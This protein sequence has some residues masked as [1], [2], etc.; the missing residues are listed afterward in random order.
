MPV[1]WALRVGESGP[2]FRGHDLSWPRGMREACA[3][4]GT[5]FFYKQ[6]PAARTEMGITLDGKMARAFPVPR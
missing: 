6:S 1:I 5:A 3:K 4:S 2:G